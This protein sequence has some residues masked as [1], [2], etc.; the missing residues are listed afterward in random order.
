MTLE[1]RLH[2]RGGQGGVT[3]AKILATLY[4]R[5]GKSVQAFGDYAGERSG[6]PIRAYTRVDDR[7]ITNRNKVNHPGHLL[8]LDPSLLDKDAVLGLAK[9]GLLLVNTSEP[10][11]ALEARFPAFRVVAL[12]AT[13]IARRHEIGSRSVVIVN[14]TIAGAYA[15]AMDLPFDVLEGTYREL[16]LEGDLAA[17]REAYETASLG[18][19]RQIVPH[20]NGAAPATGPAVIELTRHVTGPPTGLK[21]GSWRTQAPRYIE[22][23]APCTASCPA[24]NDVVGF[25]QALAHGDLAEAAEILERTQPFPSICGRVCP[26]PCMQG[27]NRRDYDG[28]VRIRALERWIGDHADWGVPERAPRTGTRIAIVGSGPAGLAAAYHLARAGHE[29]AIFEGEAELGGVLRTGIPAYRLPREV[30]DRE[31]DRIRALGVVI[32]CGE[33]LGPSAIAFL[34]KRYDAV[35]VAAG[36]GQTST[37]QAP[38]I[39]LD[40]IEE[41]TR[42]LHRVNLEGGERLRGHV[43]VLGGGNTAMDCARSAL[44]SGAA[45]VTVAYRRGRDQ[46]P[47]I[48]EEIEEARREGVA[49]LFQRQAVAFHGDGCVSSAELAEVELGEPDEGGRRR[50]VVTDRTSRF[51]CDRVLLAVGQ[52]IEYG[53][54]P[55]GH[56]VEDGRVRTADGM[57]NIFFAGDF[58]TGE[59]TVAHAIGDGRRVAGR[60]RAALEETV[61]M[62]E[63]PDRASAVPSSRIRM[64]SFAP[65]A[66]AHEIEL[67]LVERIHSFEETTQGLEAPEEAARCFSCGRCTQCDTC[68][69][70]CP[71]GVIRRIGPAYEADMDFCK[72]CGICVSEC[73]RGAIEMVS[74]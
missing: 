41:G 20:R 73:P 56:T 14:T 57:T 62:R 3:C 4:A 39:T 26:A 49:F 15:R 28:A 58:H 23:L 60:I 9:G 8:V 53:L 24:G 36:F 16:H 70:Y 6:A 59:G 10:L 44:R 45:R 19:P 50:P 64:M 38:G 72:G 69:V 47:A 37:F 7:P 71:E 65:M 12:D 48:P 40:G 67:S 33:F 13:G 17:A 1:I 68:L 42:F 51:A 29:V 46:M 63:R 74:A 2:G 30:L 18:A 61:T 66:P 25:V 21:T 22:A 43:L 32:R 31:I 27:C 35:I 5:L 55:V 11:H 54:L 52:A 34:S